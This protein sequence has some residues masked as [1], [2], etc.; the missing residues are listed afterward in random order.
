[1]ALTSINGVALSGL[2]A[3]NGQTKSGLS[4][5]NGQTIGGGGGGSITEVG[6]GSQR[7]TLTALNGGDTQNGAFPG[8]VTA[9]NLLVV[10]GAYWTGTAITFVNVTD[11]RG[12]SYTTVL[13]TQVA[14]WRPYIAYGIAPSSGA[15]TVTIDPDGATVYGSSA[16][17]EFSGV[18]TGTPV[19]ASAQVATGNSTSPLVSITTATSGAL[20][21]GSFSG[22]NV[23][24]GSGVAPGASYTQI[25]ELEDSSGTWDFN[26][27]FQLATTA[28]AYNVDW[29]KVVS[30]NWSV[31]AIAFKA[32]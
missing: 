2:S 23:T 28:Q 3:I 15:N 8:N 16:I 27:E 4:A 20:I 13:G 22:E 21:V 12:T 1:M 9:N 10:G 32:A 14:G 25:G 11:T 30:A 7:F 5:I 17:D 29:S 6:S 31:V 24:P 26:L 18:N 19:D